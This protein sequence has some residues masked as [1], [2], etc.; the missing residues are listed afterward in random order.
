MNNYLII[1]LAILIVLVGM[2]RVEGMKEQEKKKKVESLK[3]F[4]FLKCQLNINHE[5]IPTFFSC[6]RTRHMGVFQQS[7][8]EG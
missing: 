5:A 4:L 3:K 1:V 7:S 6:S 8:G 2:K